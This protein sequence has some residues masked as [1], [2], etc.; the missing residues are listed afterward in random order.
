MSKVLNLAREHQFEH[1]VFQLPSTDISDMIGDYP[2]RENGRA[3][4]KKGQDSLHKAVAVLQD[5]Q[6]VGHVR[7]V[8]ICRVGMIR[9]VPARYH[10]SA[11]VM[12]NFA[13]LLVHAQYITQIWYAKSSIVDSR[14]TLQQACIANGYT[15]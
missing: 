12:E 11:E 14:L 6:V 5:P 15:S 2:L 1:L 7:S 10:V 13:R 4:L 3:L 9:T 8:H